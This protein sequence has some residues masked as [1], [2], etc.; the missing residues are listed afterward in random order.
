MISAARKTPHASLRVGL[1]LL[2]AWAG[3]G[4][5]SLGPMPP[6]HLGEPGWRVRQGQ[7][8]WCAGRGRPDLAGEL[9]LATHP[10]GRWWVQ[11]TKEPFPV[12]V[13]RAIGNDWWIEFGLAG[14]RWSGR[15]QPPARFGWCHLATALEGRPLAASW[16]FE[17]RGGGS[18]RLHDPQT[19]EFIEGYLSP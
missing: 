7:A 3:A 8:V 14:R 16:R 9:L 19:G 18:W 2:L 17:P 13:A 5:R 12:V 11:F 10:D 4:C 1:A 15:G 6:A